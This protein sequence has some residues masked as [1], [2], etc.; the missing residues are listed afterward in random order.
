MKIAF[1]AE[2]HRGATLSETLP[3][4]ERIHKALPAVNRIWDSS[5]FST[6]YEH[7]RQLH[8]WETHAY[9]GLL[10]EKFTLDTTSVILHL[11]YT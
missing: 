2:W 3:I 4:C 5:P 11:L 9:N 1:E 7:I 8:A 10:E 6:L